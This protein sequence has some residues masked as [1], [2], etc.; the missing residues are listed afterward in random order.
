MCGKGRKRQAVLAGVF[1]DSY[2]TFLQHEQIPSSFRAGDHCSLEVSLSTLRSG[3]NA[4]RT[5]VLYSTSRCLVI[6]I[7]TKQGVKTHEQLASGVWSSL[8]QRNTNGRRYSE[9]Q[10][11]NRQVRASVRTRWCSRAAAYIHRW[12]WVCGLLGGRETNHDDG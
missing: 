11:G 2:G 9:A 3:Q 5:L 6:D 4:L 7:M 12:G 1:C 8:S 10:D